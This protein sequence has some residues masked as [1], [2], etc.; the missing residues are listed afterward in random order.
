MEFPPHSDDLRAISVTII[1]YPAGEYPH[2]ASGLFQ[3]R[4]V[5]TGS[6]YAQ[7]DLGA[8]RRQVFTR[9]GDI[10]VSLGDRPSFFAIEE[11]RD[12][13][14]V[15]ASEAILH[16]VLERL[17]ATAADLAPLADRPFRDPLVADLAIR[18]EALADASAVA[19]DWAFGLMI[20]LLLDAARRPSSRAAA[21]RLTRRT[22][23][24]IE[25]TIA[26]RLDQPVSV[27]EL[28]AIAGMSARPFSA[29]FREATGLP[30]YQLILRRRVDRAAE[31]LRDTTVPLAEV[32][33]R[34]GFTHQAHMTRT[35][36]RLQGQTPLMIR[37][38]NL[39]D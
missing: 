17:N 39:G 1:H 30:V 12:L 26:A 37:K 29:A 27:A 13:L 16:A 31:L 6:S 35:L 4:V 15:Q 19:L 22:L 38:N 36:K 5:R 14:F 8:G 23:T 18:M 3:L 25:A 20:A 32:A 2:P 24:E 34:S 28:A 11:G 33:Q 7:I 10:L 21:R 9:P